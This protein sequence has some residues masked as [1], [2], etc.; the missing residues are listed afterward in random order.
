MDEENGV[1]EEILNELR[2]GTRRQSYSAHILINRMSLKAKELI[3]DMTARL[4][5]SPDVADFK[6]SF[7]A[8][9][10]KMAREEFDRKGNR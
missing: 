5:R 2:F 1:F 10:I 3:L 8:E 4:G 9:V 6:A 7:E